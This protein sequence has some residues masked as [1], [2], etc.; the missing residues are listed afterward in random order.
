[1]KMIRSVAQLPPAPVSKAKAPGWGTGREASALECAV[2]ALA[3]SWLQETQLLKWE[4]A[5]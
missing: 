2:L 4:P 1:M 5:L 3:L